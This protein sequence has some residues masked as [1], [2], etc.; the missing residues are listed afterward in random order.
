MIV[1]G[2]L[3]ALGIEQVREHLHE[4]HLV[5]DARANFRAEI[6]EQ[7]ES[8]KE[9]LAI[10]EKDRALL[11]SVLMAD[12]D[13]SR[14]APDLHTIALQWQFLETGGWD[15][16]AAT[17]AFS[18]MDYSEVQTYSRIYA[19]QKIFNDFEEKAHGEIIV[20][21]P[22]LDA[23]SPTMDEKRLRDN[24]IQLL[25]GYSHSIDQIGHELLTQF[26]KVQGTKQ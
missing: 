18:Y 23:K 26:D 12:S 11:T 17:Q 3:I 5:E 25:L 14:S 9:H 10:W 21:S 8:L 13:R 22:L 6:E 20:L 4:K 1:L 16:V 19:S 7:R 2:I 15:A 24:D